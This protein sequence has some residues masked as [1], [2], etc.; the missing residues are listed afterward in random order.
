MGNSKALEARYFYIIYDIYDSW[1][2]GAEFKKENPE[3]ES[4]SKPKF[5][6]IS[7]SELGFKFSEIQDRG[8]NFADHRNG[9]GTPGPPLI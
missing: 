1:W 3:P 9:I 7:G 2:A 8:P 4:G 6:A 5:S